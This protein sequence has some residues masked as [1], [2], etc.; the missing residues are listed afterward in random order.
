[1]KKGKIVLALVISAAVALTSTPALSAF[2]TGDSITVNCG[3]VL[4]AATHCA[5]GSLYGVTESIPADVS[6]LIAPTNPH[7][8]RNPAEGGSANQHPFGA[9]IPV[10]Q[11]LAV[12]TNAEVSVDFAD[13]LPGWPYTWPGMT[14]W[15]SQVN[16]FIS[17]KKSAGVTNIYGYEIWN[18]PDG[19]WSSSNGDF[20]SYL[21]LQT[22]NDMRAND[23]SVK[24]VGPCYSYYN[25]T[26]MSTFLTYCKANNCLP[27]I[28]SWHELSGIANV[29]PDIKAYR[30]LETSLG[31]SPRPISINEYCDSN[32]ALEGQ[33]GSLG[34]FIGK[35]ERYEVDSACISWWFVPLPGR[36]GSLLATNT[37]KGA[38]WYFMNWY[39]QMTGNMVNVAVANDATANID[40]AAC[41][42]SSNKYISC[43][44]GGQN[45][46]TVNTTFTNIPSFI[47]STATVQVQRVDWTSKDTISTG[48]VTVST[49][50]Y[51]VTNGQITVTMTGCNASSGYRIYITPGASSGIVSG[52]TY[53][54]TS[55]MSGLNLDNY[56]STTAGNQVGQFTV[57]GGSTQLW[58]IT[59]V[60]NGY[61]TLTNQ[62]SGQNLDNNNVTTVGSHVVQWT[63]NGGSTQL[64]KIVNVS[65]NIYTLQCEMSG[66]DLDN[67]NSTTTGQ[68]V[69]QYTADGQTT[70]EWTIK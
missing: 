3:S 13:M 20:N 12:A 28:I 26:T 56:N 58:K 9:A 5:D 41:V 30:A 60:G 55:V 34:E 27:D 48:P 16:A 15:L 4:R 35:F 51:P 36:L 63:V 38:G 57:N 46:G 61:Y 25:N 32:H 40:G 1:M 64:W 68:T 24:I 19:T 14:S 66:L 29:A 70:Q 67:G 69:E 23:P 62:M 44:L 65:G 17:Q 8:V 45:S 11:R 52:N 22:Y 54:L 42:D 2:A 7:V 50:S 39:G 53:R 49:T 21:W 37:N 6:G 47:G 43:I 10:A 33:P 18:E 59:S 31:I